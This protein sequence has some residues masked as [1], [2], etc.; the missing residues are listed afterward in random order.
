MESQ[1]ELSFPEKT[2]QMKGTVL[3]AHFL[4]AVK[5]KTSENEPQHVIY[6]LSCL[7]D[8]LNMF[9]VRSV[10]LTPDLSSHLTCLSPLPF[11]FMINTAY[12][13]DTS[14]AFQLQMRL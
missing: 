13:I 3:P 8:T 10:L 1:F 11:D 12:L 7:H 9:P 14:P 4:P 5:S 6:N 2:R